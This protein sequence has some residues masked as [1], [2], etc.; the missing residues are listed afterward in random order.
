M[1]ISLIISIFIVVFFFFPMGSFAQNP[2]DPGD[3]P[4]TS[5][6]K[7]SNSAA[8]LYKAQSVANSTVVEDTLNA[9]I[10]SEALPFEITKPKPQVRKKYKLPVKTAEASV[11]KKEK[12]AKIKK[13]N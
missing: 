4:V 13:I 1:K 2:A 7:L 9:E 6:Q 12:S 3:D 11:V 8:T 5:Q 10:K